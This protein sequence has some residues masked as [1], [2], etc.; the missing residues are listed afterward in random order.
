MNQ[1]YLEYA[2]EVK[3]AMEKGQPV[4]ALESTIISHGMPYP[5]NLETAMEV[6]DIIRKE[7]AVPA[8]IALI[9]GKI[10]IGMTQEELEAFA[11]GDAIEK[12]SRRDFPKVLAKK[13]AGATTV[14]ATMICA[15]L[16][17][18]QV[19]VTGGIGG[20][21]RGAES[22]MD[23]SA[24]LQELAKTNVA[25]VCA[26]AKSIL[27]IGLTLEYLETH[28]VTVIGYETDEFPAFYTRKSGYGV[29]ATGEN[30]ADVASMLQVKRDLGLSGGV[31][32]ANPVP[33]E[34]EMQKEDVDR[35]IQI[36]LTEAI[37]EGIKGKDTTP[38]LLGRLKELSDGQTLVTNIALVK[39]N[40]VNGAKV[41]VK[42]NEQGRKQ[43]V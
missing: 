18:I 17:G 13:T 6:E 19:F 23:I 33:E 24:D 27:D 30:P 8:T 29:D 25:V 11:K 32:I 38:Y 3:E 5:Q 42:L 34:A 41:A 16:A 31:V 4:V 20:V 15:E 43:K 35:M 14:A 36:A 21:H 9:D 2:P 26:G 12:V 37:E 10:K 28:G 22:S 7:G 39:H 1:H 40:A